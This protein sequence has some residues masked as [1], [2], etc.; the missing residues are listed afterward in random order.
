MRSNIRVT[1]AAAAAAAV[2]GLP[3]AGSALAAPPAGVPAGV[4]AGEPDAAQ[5]PA[6]KYALDSKH[7]AVLSRVSHLGYSYSVFRFD[8]VEGALSWD[9]AA[10]ARSS[11]KVTVAT[12]AVSSNVEGFGKEIGDKFLKAGQFP[13]ATFVSTAFRP[14]D[15]TH[16]KV[17]GQFTLMGVTKPVTF[18][19]ELVGAGKGFF[20]KPRI[21]VNARTRINPQDFG[22]PPMM[23]A[24]IELVVDTEFEKAADKASG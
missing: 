10:P 8:K 16:G 2:L 11:L 9:P 24:P 5:A 14:I 15:A 22:L 1:A 13:Q 17:D 3:A 23:T 6:G 18:D 21:G 20:G 19:V 7:A 4:F 12:D